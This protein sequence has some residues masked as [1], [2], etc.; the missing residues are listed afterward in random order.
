MSKPDLER[1]YANQLLT[2]MQKLHELQ[3]AP[4]P[5][6]PRNEHPS[7]DA[8]SI[9]RARRECV[10][11]LRQYQIYL[12]EG[13]LPSVEFRQSVPA[14]GRLADRIQTDEFVEYLTSLDKRLR[15]A[16]RR[17]DQDAQ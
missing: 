6:L 3:A 14:L 4:E 12:L 5:W 7:V 2:R 16:R 13:G 10:T 17:N 11:A 8:S 15:A 9:R 1:F